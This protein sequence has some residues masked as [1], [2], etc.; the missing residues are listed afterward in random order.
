MTNLIIVDNR[1]YICDQKAILPGRTGEARE[2]IIEWSERY[3]WEKE[4]WRKN[5]PLDYY[6]SSKR[7]RNNGSSQLKSLS[8][9]NWPSY[10]DHLSDLADTVIDA[11]IADSFAAGG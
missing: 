4:E 9:R 8:A 1:S 10:E 6:L 5:N 11:G 7:W 3:A 2:S